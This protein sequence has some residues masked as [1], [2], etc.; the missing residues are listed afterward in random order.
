M[1]KKKAGVN[2]KNKAVIITLEI[3]VLITIAAIIVIVVK[4]GLIPGVNSTTH[5]V[6]ENP[7][8]SEQPAY[9]RDWENDYSFFPDGGLS[10]TMGETPSGETVKLPDPSGWS[11]QDI[12]ALINNS[13]SRTKNYKN[14][15]SA[16][17]QESFEANIT[18]FSG[19]EI[20]QSVVNAMI[21]WVV[22]PVDEM[23][24]YTNGTAINSEGEY[25]QIILPKDGSFKL[26]ASGVV[27]ADARLSG[28]EYIVTVS[29]VE[30]A[31]GMY[32]TPVHNAGAIGFLNVADFDISFMDV[33]SADI[34]YKGS[35]IEIH[36]NSAGYIT[37]AL[38]DMPVEIQ[39]SAHKGPISGSATFVG[40]QSEMWELTYYQ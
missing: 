33:D 17:H 38:Y 40:A 11:K 34:R 26:D 22:K 13:V 2:P 12:V 8:W 14:K 16:H 3:A 39:G 27:N 18:E 32:E 15:V 31:V 35:T 7:G 37:Y 5:Y 1:N 10:I 6:I 21:G 25:V 29:L 23:L 28:D 9:T 24:Y 19:G 30:E 4:G 36:I 20:T